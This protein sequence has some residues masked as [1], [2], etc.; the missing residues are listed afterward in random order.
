[1]QKSTKASF[2]VNLGVW[3]GRMKDDSTEIIMPLQRGHLFPNFVVMKNLCLTT[4][5]FLHPTYPL[6]SFPFT[7]N[8]A[9]GGLSDGVFGRG[10]GTCVF[11]LALSLPGSR[12]G[13]LRHPRT[14]SLRVQLPPWEG[15]VLGVNPQDHTHLN[16]PFKGKSADNKADL[17]IPI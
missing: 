8:K 7:A 11:S 9:H 4:R 1:M 13:A 2:D 6:L 14:G 12:P 5:A 10:V 15:R 17:L 16:F 3:K